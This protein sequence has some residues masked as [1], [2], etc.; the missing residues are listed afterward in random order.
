MRP[1]GSKAPLSPRTL[2]SVH[3]AKTSRLLTA[4]SAC[5]EHSDTTRDN[6]ARAI[7]F[8]CCENAMLQKIND[9]CK[10][11][12][13]TLRASTKV[14][15]TCQ[16]SHLSR[17]CAYWANIAAA[18]AP[19]VVHTMDLRGGLLGKGF[20]LRRTRHKTFPRLFQ[21]KA[22]RNYSSAEEKWTNPS[23]ELHKA[24]S[25]LQPSMTVGRRRKPEI[26]EKVWTSR[27]KKIMKSNL[28]NYFW[29]RNKRVLQINWDLTY[30]NCS[31]SS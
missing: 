10:L 13:K 7:E 26:K 29:V 12:L 8:R 19:R 27:L 1:I 16:V 31:M 14:D 25:L 24:D 3:F 11:L 30:R 5:Q 6:V 15:A 28:A 17:F 9:W 20:G 21:E 22:Q 23:K 18:A 4:S 2:S